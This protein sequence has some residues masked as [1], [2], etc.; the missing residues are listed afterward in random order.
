MNISKQEQAFMVAAL[1]SARIYDDLVF[2][3]MIKGRPIV[4]C[5]TMREDHIKTQE[6]SKALIERLTND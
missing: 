2:E 1:K 3:D 5:G 4:F 6:Y